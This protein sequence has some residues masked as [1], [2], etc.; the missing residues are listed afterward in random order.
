MYTRIHNRLFAYLERR[1]KATL[2]LLSLAMTLALWYVDSFTGD[3]S[4]I[5]FYIAPIFLAAWF[6]G[7]RPGVAISLA[8]GVANILANPGRFKSVETSLLLRNYWDMCLESIYLLLLALMFATMRR[9]FDHEQQM[10]RTDPLTEALNRRS[11]YELLEFEL[12]KCR[13]YGR[14]FSLAYLDLD[15]FKQV[16]DGH[17]HQVGDE[18]LRVMVGQFR[19]RLRKSDVVARIGGDEFAV[20][21]VETGADAALAVI[22][23]LRQ[24]MAAAMEERGWP[25]TLSIGLVT[26]EAASHSVDEMMASVD[27]LMYSVKAGGKNAVTQKVFGTI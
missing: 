18:L 4:F 26:Y 15:N 2:I 24:Q 6:V 23:Q 21:L 9:H 17:G 3:Y 20:L 14:P 27:A 22:Q 19:G 25:V 8:C 11:F 16:N 10:A 13:R 5:L 1:T 12:S 7:K